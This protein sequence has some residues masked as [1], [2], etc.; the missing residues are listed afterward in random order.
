MPKGLRKQS[1]G[2]T[3]SHCIYCC[4][5]IRS[6]WPWYV[7]KFIRTR[8]GEAKNNKGSLNSIGKGTVQCP[9]CERVH[10]CRVIVILYH[11]PSTTTGTRQSV[12]FVKPNTK[13]KKNY[14]VQGTRLDNWKAHICVVKS[15]INGKVEQLRR[16]QGTLQDLGQ[17][18]TRHALG[19]NR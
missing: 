3:L 7:D 1:P 18:V 10:I 16:A 6:L 13:K 8:V 19:I 15:P 12:R 2:C 14:T 9:E 11:H 5:L 4:I 17:H